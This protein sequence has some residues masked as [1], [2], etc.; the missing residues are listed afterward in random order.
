MV[1]SLKSLVVRLYHLPHAAA[2][3][4]LTHLK[5]LDIAGLVEHAS[6]HIRING[7]IEVAHQHLA[8]TRCRDRDRH[9][10]KIARAREASRTVPQA[11][12][13]THSLRHKGLLS[14]RIVSSS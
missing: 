6:A 9:E 7:H 2:L 14:A 5:R 8:G 12:F 13:T 4:R 11:N 10:L 3:E 1:A